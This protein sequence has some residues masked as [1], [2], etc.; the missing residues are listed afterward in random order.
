MA[1]P[2]QFIVHAVTL[3]GA[4]SIPIR[5]AYGRDAL[6]RFV[7]VG[8]RGRWD[9]PDEYLVYREEIVQAPPP[10]PVEVSPTAEADAMPS[11]QL[12]AVRARMQATQ[13]AI[14]AQKAVKNGA[15]KKPSVSK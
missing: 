8:E 1:N 7:L 10:P 3:D 6:G 12:E 2:T 13:A 9:I 11:E 5:G 14:R 15:T 4:M